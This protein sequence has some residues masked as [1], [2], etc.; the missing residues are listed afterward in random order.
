M[1]D[2]MALD[3]ESGR[4]IKKTR[5]GEEGGAGGSGGGAAGSGSTGT[6]GGSGS[7]SPVKASRRKQ[8]SGL[9]VCCFCNAPAG[10]N[11][12]ARTEASCGGQLLAGS[13]G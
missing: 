4:L 12:R 8:R 9:F 7:S 5:F 6:G 13:D 3:T 1:T 2:L 11:L 10:T